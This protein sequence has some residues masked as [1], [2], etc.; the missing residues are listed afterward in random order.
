MPWWF[1]QDHYTGIGVF[2]KVLKLP[3]YI[4]EIG[5]PFHVEVGGEGLTELPKVSSA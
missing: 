3:T 2:I 4:F 1:V 5:S